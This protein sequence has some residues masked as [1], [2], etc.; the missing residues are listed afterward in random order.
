MECVCVLCA[1][2]KH[3][4]HNVE[5][6]AE[7]ASRQRE[8]LSDSIK[9]CKR[10]TQKLDKAVKGMKKLE[11]NFKKVEN[12]VRERATEVVMMVRAQER[13]LISRLHEQLGAG[14]IEYLENKEHLNLQ[15]NGVG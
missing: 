2:N 4:S 11:I 10:Q 7:S 9:G 6:F 8:T 5:T 13:E 12:D 14:F 1:F 15:V 3:R